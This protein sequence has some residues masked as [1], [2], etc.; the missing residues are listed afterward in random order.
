[1]DNNKIVFKTKFK[2]FDKKGV[3]DYIRN[4]SMRR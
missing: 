2:G 4:L 3:V 1:M